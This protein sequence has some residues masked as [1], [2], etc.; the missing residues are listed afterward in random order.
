MQLNGM[1]TIAGINSA[2]WPNWRNQF[3][4]MLA[5]NAWK[6]QIRIEFNEMWN[7]VEIDEQKPDL[8]LATN[9]VYNAYEAIMQAQYK[10][11]PSYM[12][13]SSAQ[14]AYESIMYKTAEL[15]RDVNA[16]FSATGERCYALNTDTWSFWQHKDAQY[17]PEP[18]RIPVNQAAVVIPFFA[19]NNLICEARRLNG[20]M[21]DV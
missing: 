20:V 16:N 11:E 5:A 7:S 17:K 9:D 8:M 1:G 21:Y 14:S 4:T 12:K 3:R 10:H 6:N 13:Q 2:D 18:A 19:M 15:V